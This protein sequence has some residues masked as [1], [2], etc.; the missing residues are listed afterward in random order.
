M[1]TPLEIM[2]AALALPVPC[3]ECGV[4][5]NLHVPESPCLGGDAAARIEAKAVTMLGFLA[6][7]GLIHIHTGP[8]TDDEIT[9][10]VKWLATTSGHLRYS[11]EY[12]GKVIESDADLTIATRSAVQSHVGDADTLD[13]IARVNTA[14]KAHMADRATGQ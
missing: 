2:V 13:K 3:P 5:G 6:E 8:P 12:W 14:L 11:G 10:M 4:E 9:G 7:Q 1:S